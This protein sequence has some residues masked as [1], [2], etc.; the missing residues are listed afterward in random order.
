LKIYKHQITN[1]LE[2]FFEKRLDA[3][4]EF[5]IIK[6]H[7]TELANH[8]YKGV[9]SKVPVVF[10][11]INNYHSDYLGKGIK[12]L[13]KLSWTLADCQH[14]IANEY[15]FKNWEA[16]QNLKKQKYNFLFEKSVNTLLEGN[17]D[18]LQII[19]DQHPQLLKTIS[20]YGHRATLLHY[21]ASNGVE[22][23]R[24][25]V[26]LNLPDITKYLLKSSAD[27][28]AKMKVYGGEFDVLSLL[29]T[30]AHPFAAGVGEEMKKIL[31]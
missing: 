22:M 9:Q 15:G 20:Q 13:Q 27:K 4:V 23:W 17:L 14:T 30:S 3:Y 1:D 29:V 18:G 28:N 26:P 24:Q 7:L 16:V 2:S 6:N 21:V 12:E 31:K 11:L 5:P 10:T 19:L 8:L 25:K